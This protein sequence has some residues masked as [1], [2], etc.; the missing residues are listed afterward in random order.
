MMPRFAPSTGRLSGP[1]ARIARSG[2]VCALALALSAA[3]AAAQASAA[4]I[5]IPSPCVIYNQANV[6][7]GVPI[8]GAGFT[9]GDDVFY[10]STTGDA[11]GN[12]TVAADGTFSGTFSPSTLDTFAAP[13][14]T[15]FT[16]T[17][18]DD[19][20]VTASTT[21][22]EAPFAVATKPAKA[23]PKQ[24]VTFTF[25]GFTEGQPIY[26]HFL[27]KNKVVTTVEYG[28][29]QGPCG[30]LTTR[31]TLYP[32]HTKFTQYKIQI[33]DS[34]KYSAATSPNLKGSLEPASS[35]F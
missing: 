5:T 13:A 31:K 12:A 32:K 34:K 18:T 27:H 4:T 21:F 7:N 24:K 22:L 25:T 14:V 11:S 28:V 26:I 10:N 33:D 30:T 35:V 15:P 23:K 8:S 20:N 19:D 9:P 1:I 16:M 29:A 3:V 6:T 17:A 2:A